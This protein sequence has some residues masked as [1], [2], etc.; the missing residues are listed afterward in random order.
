MKTIFR[1]ERDQRDEERE[2]TNTLFVLM[3]NIH[4]K[5]FTSF[6]RVW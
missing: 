5:I 1:V 4:D 3:E 2:H 6:S